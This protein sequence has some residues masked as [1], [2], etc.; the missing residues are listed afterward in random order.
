MHV[1]LL[2]ITHFCREMKAITAAYPDVWLFSWPTLNV[3]INLDLFL[4]WNWQNTTEE[5][6]VH[7]S[8]PQSL[9][10][11]FDRHPNCVWCQLLFINHS[12]GECCQS[13]TT[14]ALPKWSKW[15]SVSVFKW[16]WKCPQTSV[17]V[18]CLSLLRFIW[19]FL[20]SRNPNREMLGLVSSL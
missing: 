17:S 7:Q 12:H 4:S 3:K 2:C 20:P 13:L 10:A 18:N 5:Q 14:L 8:D 9:W 11:S 16:L 19:C 1:T 6:K 15:W